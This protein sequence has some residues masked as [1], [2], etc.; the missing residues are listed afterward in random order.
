MS[1]QGQDGERNWV[2]Q[3]RGYFYRENR[4]GYTREISAAGLYTED[5]AR[6]EASIEPDTMA[7]HPVTAFIDQWPNQRWIPICAAPKDGRHIIGKTQF[8]AMEIWWHRDIY[9]GEYW[10]DEG[11]SEPEPTHWIPMPLVA[12][13]T[14]NGGDNG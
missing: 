13:P 11:D 10:T 1:T 2:I 5:E 9:E 14:S 8:G 7:A 6:R 12:P 3:K 4:S